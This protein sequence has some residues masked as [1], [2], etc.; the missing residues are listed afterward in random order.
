MSGLAGS[1][2]GD[3]SLI[4]VDKNG[5]S[6]CGGDQRHVA[7]Q[8]HVLRTVCDIVARLAGT[9]GEQAS[10]CIVDGFVVDAP[11]RC[12]HAMHVSRLTGRRL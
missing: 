11:A 7:F 9:T 12:R 5:A 2:E 1:G 3:T 4:Y 6:R 10:G 8:P